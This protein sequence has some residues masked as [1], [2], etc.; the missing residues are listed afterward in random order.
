MIHRMIQRPVICLVLSAAALLAQRPPAVPLVTN[1]PYF[2]IWSMADQ[3]TADTTRHW[4]GTPQS[5]RSLIRIDGK[6]YRLMGAERNDNVPALPQLKLEITPT[7][8]VYKFAGAA[9]EVSLTFTTPL[10]PHDLDM[11]SWPVTYLTWSARSADG[12]NHAVQIYFDAS[13]EIA[14]NTSDQPVNWSRLE[15]NGLRVLRMGSREQP[16]LQKSGDN[17]RIDWGYFYVATP[18]YDDV[19]QAAHDRTITRQAFENSGAVIVEDAFAEHNPR[20]RYNPV[21]NPV[22][23]VSFDLG[24]VGSQP[25]SRYVLLA[26]DDLYSLEYFNRRVRPYWRRNGREASGLLNTATAEYS[27]VMQECKRFDDELMADLTRTGGKEYAQLCALAYRQSIAAHKLAVDADGTLLFF[28][29]ENFSNG[30]I[31][32]VDVFYPSSPLFLLMNTKLLRASVE[33]VLQYA[34]MSRWPWPYAPHD[35]GTYPLANGQT[36][37]GGE[38][39]ERNQM[40][41]EE[42]GNM[43]LLVAAIAKA[44]GNAELANKYWPLLTKWAEYL[45]DKGLDPE[46]QLCTDDFAGHLARNANLSLKAIE[47]IAGYAMLA[48]M[49]GRKSESEKYRD[50]ALDYA[51]KWMKLADDGDH[52]VLAFGNP[53]TWSQKYNLVWDRILGL[54]LFPPEVARKEVAY[55]KTKQNVYGLPLDNRAPYT[56][57]DWLVW[58]ATLADNPADFQALIAPAYKWMNET[59]T[60]VPLTDWYMTTDG[61]QRGFQARSV[62][63]GLFIKM[64]ADPAMWEKWKQ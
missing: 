38:Q 29:K 6:S 32:T 61:K 48:G 31:D 26:Y 50:I 12:K 33:P 3:L 8:T 53:G 18:T 27:Q 49:T 24:S 20:V 39:S 22:L 41:V 57:L 15:T 30:S 17:L 40:P 35:L 11:L 4:T 51:R 10:L 45:R 37:G 14:V 13:S 47:G 52:Y 5:L 36:Y 16:M 63:G 59:P 46:N 23:A 43:L 58:T 55:Y 56:K 28:P 25:V 1:D 42:S 54:N 9:V 2:S 64:L 34:S 60:R 19:R 44:D 21:R 62:V 7:Q